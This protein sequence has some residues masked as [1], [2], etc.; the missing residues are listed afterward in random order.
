M[1][2]TKT[3]CKNCG[4]QFSG[5]YCNTCGEKVYT[6]HDKSILH[7]FEDALHFITHF[8]GTFINTLRAILT[9]PGK[10]SL[11]YCNGIR[12]KYFRPLAFFMILVISYLIFPI[13]Q[14]LNMPFREFLNYEYAVNISSKKTGVDIDS[15]YGKI[16]SAQRTRIFKTKYEAM[17]YRKSYTDS[18]YKTIPKLA[19]LESTYN[20]NSEKTSKFLLLIL[21]PLTAIVLKLLSLRRKKYFFDHLVLATEINSFF[22]LFTFLILPVVALLVY[23]LAPE[24]APK[25]ITETTAVIVAY[26]AIG[27]YCTIAFH[28]FYKDRWWWSVLKGAFVAFTHYFIALVIYKLILFTVIVYFF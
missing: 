17:V 22:M 10:L 16:D 2:N 19:K 8:E 20:K 13:F 15:L 23:E 18:V 3:T 24:T 9:R 4:N 5:K 27:L 28:R 6:D 14:G 11:D 21:I 25:I 1:E 26:S 12:K 7:F